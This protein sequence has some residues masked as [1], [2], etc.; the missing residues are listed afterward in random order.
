MHEATDLIYEVLKKEYK[1]CTQ[2]GY[3]PHVQVCEA[4]DDFTLR[5]PC[6]FLD[7]DCKC[8]R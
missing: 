8:D 2:C 6:G 1:Y 5:C 4:C 7:K 3:K